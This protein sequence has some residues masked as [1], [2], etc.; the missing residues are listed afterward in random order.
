MSKAYR[1]QKQAL[2]DL[3]MI[4]AHPEHTNV[5][6]YSCESFY[7]RPDGSSPRITSIAARNLK[8]GQTLSFS[9]HKFGELEGYPID[10]LDAHYNKLEKAMLDAFF[11]FAK[12]KRDYK[13]VHWNMR[14]ENYGFHALEL[15]HRI[16][17]GEPFTILD[18]KKY[19]LSRVLVGIYGKAYTGHPRLESLM[20][21]NHISNRG[22]KT[23]KEEAE[24]FDEGNYVALHQSTL[25]KADILSNICQLA[26]EGDLKTNSKW[27]Q[28]NCHSIEAFMAW[29]SKHPIISFI[30]VAMSLLANM[31][32]FW[33]M[34]S[35][36]GGRI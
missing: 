4:W 9:I 33:Q 6:H 19:D 13:W 32:Y 14:D 10:Q 29:F 18:E 2:K 35:G 25:C 12:D 17:H 5:I 24:L 26:Y 28:L 36:F 1:R 20:L 31:I 34:F 3:D 27:Y 7:D 16:L 21:M 22:F 15:R 11:E 23:G 8:T 30:I